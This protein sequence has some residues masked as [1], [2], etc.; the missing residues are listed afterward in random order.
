MNVVLYVN[1]FLPSLGGREFVVHYLAA[2]L[3]ALGHGVRVVGPAGFWRHR[4]VRPHYPLHRW[5]TL[6]GLFPEQVARTSLRLD[7]A[8]WDGDVIHAHST[9]PCGWNALRVRGARGTP[10]V[11][12][13]HGN[14]INRIPEIGHGLRLDPELDRKITLALRSAERV[15][16]ISTHIRTAILDTGVDRARVPLIPNGV[17]A[18]RFLRA[19]DPRVF[20]W[21]GVPDDSRLLVSIG[22]YKPRKGQDH[23]VRAMP[24]IVKAEPRARLVLVGEGTEALRPLIDSLAMQDTVVLT[25]GLPPP[26]QVLLR[27]ST[28]PGAGDGAPPEDPLAALLCSAALYLSAGIDSNAE[29]LSLAVLEAMAA[30][31]PVIATS[32]SGNTDVV[33]DGRNGLLVPPADPVAMARTV[34]EALARPELL[35]RMRAGAH[36][37]ASGFTW[38]AVAERYL[39]VYQEALDLR[40]AAA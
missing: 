19:P 4:N 27:D 17:D 32:I 33:C 30:G 18:G 28:T 21:L 10:V 15:T 25:G 12:T 29:G 3:Q 9:Y 26:T 5:P 13:P 2:E 22:R 24:A 31:L 20:D 8:L 14:D 36:S 16:A 1:S 6:R 38:R 11:I 34:I 23:L 35:A 37:T 40:R 39:V 7:M